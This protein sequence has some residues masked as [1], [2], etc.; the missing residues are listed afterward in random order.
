VGQTPRKVIL[1]LDFLD[2]LVRPSRPPATVR[3]AQ[4]GYTVDEL[5]WKFDAMF[6]LTSLMDALTTLQIQHGAEVKTITPEGFDPLLEYNKY[7]REEGYFAIFRQRAIEYARTFIRKPHALTVGDTG[8]SP[9]LD[10]LRAIMAIAARDN[11]E[12]QI[13]IYPYH[14][15]M[16]AMFE[17]T[18]LWPAFEQW[19]ELLAQEVATV[20]KKNP[21]ARIALWDF[22]GFSIIQCE[23]IPPIND[24]HAVTRWYWES[25]HFKQSVGD[26][27][28]ARLSEKK[29]GASMQS[30][31]LGFRLMS[32]NLL[33]NQARVAR[34]R[35]DCLASTPQIFDDASRLVQDAR[36]ELH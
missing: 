19:K 29:P 13:L 24:K 17:Q 8:T 5:H 33:E 25:G 28:L 15:H 35:S 4:P 30:D 34:E 7:A 9:G 1:G 31:K 32:S 12:L 6:S 16:L 2:F 18:G 22:S 27:I 3:A 26:L 36:K 20:Q 21:E 14:A 10:D 23:P 11:I